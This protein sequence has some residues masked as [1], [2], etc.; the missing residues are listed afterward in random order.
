MLLGVAGS[1][2]DPTTVLRE[3]DAW[4]VVLNKNQDLLGK[5]MLVLRRESSDVLDVEPEEWAAFRDEL[6]TVRAAVDQLFQPDRW[7]H[8]FLMNADAQV[9]CHVVPRY[10]AA[11]EWDRL[12]FTDPHF[13]EVFGREQ[14]ILAPAQLQ[15]LRRAIQERLGRSTPAPQH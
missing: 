1:T 7:N 8:A 6:R 4:R 12:T 10:A 14:R 15:R 13:G 2:I 5:T 9:H 11:R 3:G